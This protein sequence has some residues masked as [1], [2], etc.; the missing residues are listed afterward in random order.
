MKRIFSGC[1]ILT[2]SLVA[3]N[4]WSDMPLQVNYGAPQELGERTIQPERQAY[5]NETKTNIKPS[6]FLEYYGSKIGSDDLGGDEK[7]N[8]IG[9]GI[10]FTAAN[11][12]S[13]TFGVNFQKNSDWKSTEIDIKGGYR[14]YDQSN[15][16]ADASLGLGYAWID[17]D[18]YDIKLRYVTLPIELEV[19][20]YFQSNL[21]AYAGLG[22]K[23]LYIDHYDDVCVSYFCG[24]NA[25][26]VLDMDG[27]TYKMGIRYNF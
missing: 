14:F 16:Y 5:S 6:V 18:D 25:S 2:A 12:Y 23:W 15:T 19:G 26:E 17:A 21:A 3:T 20:H 8:G 24:T 7:L 10:T 13:T 4:T 11:T 27:I 22:Y 9:T 1:V